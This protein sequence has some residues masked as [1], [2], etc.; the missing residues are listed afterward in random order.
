MEIP[1][2]KNAKHSTVSVRN[3]KICGTKVGVERGYSAK[4]VIWQEIMSWGPWLS[5]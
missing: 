5:R 4:S 2:E 3:G 1:K